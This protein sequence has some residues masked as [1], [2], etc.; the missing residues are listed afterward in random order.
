MNLAS[1][2]SLFAYA[3]AMAIIGGTLFSRRADDTVWFETSL[4]SLVYFLFALG[5]AVS[6]DRERA[7][8]RVWIVLAF[9]A[10]LFMPAAV[11]VIVVAERQLLPEGLSG[12][13]IYVVSVLA[14]LGLA[15][16][17][18]RDI[19]PQ[20]AA[21]RLRRIV[22]PVILV[23]GA[24]LVFCSLFARITDNDFTGWNV[25]LRKP[26]A[27]WVTAHINVGTPLLFGSPIEWL[28]PFYAHGGYPTYLAV[29]LA[30]VVILVALAARRLSI[31]R[32]RESALVA[33]PAVIVSLASLWVL[34]DIFWGWH[35]DLSDSPWAAALGTV[36]WFVGPLFGAVL[37]VPVLWKQRETW[38]LRAFLLLL[39][40]LGAFN[41]EPLQFYF[42]GDG[43]HLAGLAFLIIG[44]LLESLACLDLLAYRAKKD[45]ELVLPVGEPATRRPP[46]G[47]SSSVKRAS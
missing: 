29:L 31:D 27:A 36:L 9:L 11:V 30:T 10:L 19:H 26:D 18:L 16:L 8:S 44:L 1:R 4:I 35:F 17:L 12:P 40:P 22:V 25:L 2:I 21:H 34:N 13:V 47:S 39:L 5:Y 7:P 37:L 38:R 33:V 41:L 23:C 15:L 43:I 6:Q 46:T 3:A 28:Q 14:Y 20:E 24:A 42:G 45:L 32:S